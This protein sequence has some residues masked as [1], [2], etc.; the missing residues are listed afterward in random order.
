[1]DEWHIVKSLS[2]K[3]FLGVSFRDTFRTN[4]QFCLVNMQGDSNVTRVFCFDGQL[5][6]SVFKFLQKFGFA[7][8]TV[9]KYGRTWR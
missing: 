2:H 3:H 7:G 9:I 6:V 1:M 8:V 5:C 4:S